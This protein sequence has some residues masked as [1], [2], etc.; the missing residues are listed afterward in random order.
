MG[1]PVSSLSAKMHSFIVTVRL[2]S[3]FTI[4]AEVT[5]PGLCIGHQACS[6]CASN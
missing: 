4:F 3:I 5:P 1:A 6:E 2:F